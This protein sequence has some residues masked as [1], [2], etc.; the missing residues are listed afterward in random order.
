[1]SSGL[2]ILG[3]G[4]DKPV[5]DPAIFKSTVNQLINL[6][7]KNLADSGSK[8]RQ[9]LEIAKQKIVGEITYEKIREHFNG[10]AD[11]LSFY[12]QQHSGDR[13]LFKI[14]NGFEPILRKDKV[15]A[16]DIR[17]FMAEQMDKLIQSA[18]SERDIIKV[19]DLFDVS[20]EEAS[21]RAMDEER[22]IRL[23]SLDIIK[24]VTDPYINDVLTMVS[25][26]SFGDDERAAETVMAG[27]K[28]VNDLYK[29]S[30]DKIQSDNVKSQTIIP[31]RERAA[32]L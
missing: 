4:A 19:A 26:Y 1:M 15:A 27:V 31:F 23:R 32:K 13:L 6:I 21:Q 18:P 22:E 16:A 30:M 3:A 9:E 7:E 2:I 20:V 17:V 8:S 14:R 10:S 25:S 24:F 11:V 12:H 28:S 29:L 5:I